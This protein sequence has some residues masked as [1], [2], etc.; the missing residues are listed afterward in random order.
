MRSM[1][2]PSLV[3]ALA[4]GLAIGPVSEAATVKWGAYTLRSERVT[5]EVSNGYRDEV[6]VFSILD[7]TDKA[8][9][10]VR[11]RYL[12]GWRM[13]DLNRTGLPELEVVT[14][15]GGTFHGNNYCYLTQDGGLR[16]VF[17]VSAYVKRIKDLDGDG[18]VEVECEDGEW[19]D[20]YFGLS[21]AEQGC[22]L[23]ILKPASAAA[24]ATYKDAT[25]KFPSLVTSFAE[26]NRTA[27]LKDP[28]NKRW[29]G[30]GRGALAAYVC[31]MAMI[32][33]A[34]AASAWVARNAPPSDREWFRQHRGEMVKRPG[35]L[36]TWRTDKTVINA[37]LG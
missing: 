23:R 32:G 17:S 25:P 20:T 16:H 27:Y 37:E 4:T 3:L 21:H 26:A 5:Q 14:S 13:V 15:T 31:G 28:G 33:Q 36:K 11:D 2:S 35:P 8:V 12:I 9:R 34:E 19:E 6:A 18:L 7:R 29:A 1:T 30:G 10:Q 24:G 22:V